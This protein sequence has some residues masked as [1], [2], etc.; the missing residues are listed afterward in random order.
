MWAGGVLEAASVTL[1]KSPKIQAALALAVDSTQWPE[2]RA[3]FDRI[4]QRGLDKDKPLTAAEDL[5]FRLAEL[6]ANL[7]HIGWSASAF[8]LSR[9]LAGRAD[10]LPPGWRVE[11]AGS[12]PPPGCR[13]G[14][15]AGSRVIL[16]DRLDST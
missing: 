7:A 13:P 12:S 3:V 15:V 4:R 14:R 11:G 16:R 5:C 6:V 1:G 10:R 8:R 2:G 9:R